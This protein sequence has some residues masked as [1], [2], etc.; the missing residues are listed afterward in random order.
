MARHIQVAASRIERSLAG[1]TEGA[2]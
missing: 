2:A 1:A